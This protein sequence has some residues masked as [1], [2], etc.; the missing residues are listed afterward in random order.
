MKVELRFRCGVE[1][2]SGDVHVTIEGPPVVVDQ[3]AEGARNAVMYH[4]MYVEK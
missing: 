2:P 1:G 3:I 4:T